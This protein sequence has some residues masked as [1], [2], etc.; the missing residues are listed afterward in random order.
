MPILFDHFLVFSDFF[1]IF[2]NADFGNSRGGSEKIGINR[3]KSDLS[4]R[5][6]LSLPSCDWYR[7]YLA[8]WLNSSVGRAA[9]L[10]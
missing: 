2:S 6:P 8:M 7:I 5:D 9:D 3:K 4:I 1:P 10:I